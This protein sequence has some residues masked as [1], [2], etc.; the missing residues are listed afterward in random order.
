MEVARIDSNKWSI[1]IRGFGSR[2]T[3]SVLVLIDGRTVFTPLLDGTYWEVQDT[4]IE[5]VDRIEVIRG[6]G[7]KPFRSERRQWSA[8]IITKSA[9]ETRGML[10][11]AGG[12]NQEQGFLGFRYGGGNGKGLDYRIYGKGFTRGPEQ[13][14]DGRN[15]DDWR[16]GQLG[17]RADWTP[18]NRDTVTVQGDIYD[19]EAGES[20]TA[21]TYAAPYS[22][23]VDEN[24][25]LSGGNIMIRWTRAIHDGNDIQVQ[26]YYDRTNRHEP[27]FGE[28]RDTVDMDFLQHL[29]LPWRQQ[30]SWG[31]GVRIS[32]A[33]DLDVVS[34]LTFMPARRTDYLA[35]AFLQDE[36]ALVDQRL[37]LI[38]GTKLLKTSF[39]DD[40]DFEP[41]VRLLYTPTEKDTF[42]TAYT[43]ALRTPSDAEANF[44]LSG[45]LGFSGTTPYFA[46]FSAN[47]GFVPEQMNGYELGYRRLLGAN[48]YLDLTAFYN[49]YHDLFS[50]DI[51]GA[52]F[53]EAIPAPDH[54]LL[55]A[56]FG[57]G[58][59]GSTK[60]AEVA[61]EWRP[62]DYWR[63]RGSYSHLHMNVDRAP[64]SQD[65]GSAAQI[66]GSSPE[67]ETMI[68]SSFDLSKNLQLDLAFRYVSELPRLHIPSYS[69]GDALPLR[70]AVLEKLRSVSL[71]Q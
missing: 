45:F 9:K 58:L 39:T 18:N 28:L 68:Q 30:L 22:R 2:L 49:H 26:V 32:P 31:V 42:W 5:D 34:G 6:P 56:Q 65:V 15:Y 57:N 48:V 52:P 37:S 47:P 70:L 59:R 61:V 53:L 43:H 55:P 17:F 25:Q 23:V 20:V 3:R 69:T 19:E 13:H 12:G 10:A 66:V 46:R 63:L 29:R 71:G 16:S 36:I 14:S 21:V 8:T 51:L 62:R 1:G 35:T 40:A 7:G 50:E 44:N 54:L 38:L 64:G 41:S 67:H 60:G 4:L 33:K 11:S 24:A 27:N